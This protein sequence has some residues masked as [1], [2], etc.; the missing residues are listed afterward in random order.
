MQSGSHT[1]VCVCTCTCMHLF[2][3][4]LPPHPLPHPLPL[5]PPPP[6]PPPPLSLSLSLSLSGSG[7]VSLQPAWGAGSHQCPWLQRVCAPC[8]H[9]TLPGEAQPSN[10]SSVLLKFKC[11][12][13][14][15]SHT[16]AVCVLCTCTCTF[17][18]AS[19]SELHIAVVWFV[20]YCLSSCLLSVLAD[21][22]KMDRLWALTISTAIYIVNGRVCV[23]QTALPF[24]SAHCCA[25][26]TA[27]Q[28]EEDRECKNVHVATKMHNRR[29]QLYT[30]TTPALS[31][32]MRAAETN[33]ARKARAYLAY[34]DTGQ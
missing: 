28:N 8:C 31:L 7:D 6:P 18:G 21:C 19:L 23:A 30:C 26:K 2:Y 33:K 32:C 4:L 9:Q 13:P 24:V 3:I 1:N 27:E 16:M 15:C 22:A 11:L 14:Y 12:L 5:P 29:R 34:T 20:L 10:C 25:A 17:I